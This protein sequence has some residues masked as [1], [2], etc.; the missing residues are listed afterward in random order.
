MS[1]HDTWRGHI[2]RCHCIALSA[3]LNQ[4][5]GFTCGVRLKSAEGC[6]EAPNWVRWVRWVGPGYPVYPPRLRRFTQGRPGGGVTSVSCR[7]RLALSL[8]RHPPLRSNPSPQPI[9]FFLLLPC[10]STTIHPL[11]RITTHIHTTAETPLSAHTHISSFSVPSS[12]RQ[13]LAY[14]LVLARSLPQTH[15][16]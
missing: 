14:R 11:D 15:S 3:F 9:H 16:G 2:V 1:C 13:A 4:A 10:H 7:R 6:S 8:A 12:A 5:R